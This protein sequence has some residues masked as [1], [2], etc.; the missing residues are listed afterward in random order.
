MHRISLCGPWTLRLNGD[1]LEAHRNFHAPP[2]IIDVSLNK[3]NVLEGK[4]QA[5][6]EFH[7]CSAPSWPVGELL[8]NQHTV[9]SL[10]PQGHLEK[11]RLVYSFDPVS[12]FGTVEI[13]GILLPFNAL[14]LVWNCWPAEW[15]PVSGRYSPSHEHPVHIDSWL[16]IYD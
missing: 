15:Q 3:S 16:E 6:L 12:S 1:R 9:G 5:S 4:P 2:G 13:T 10:P 11:D 8:I 14:V 7:W